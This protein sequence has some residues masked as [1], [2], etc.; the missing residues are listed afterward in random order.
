M[1][2]LLV[3]HIKAGG[4]LVHLVTATLPDATIRWT[5]EGGFVGWGD[6]IWT[7]R[8]ATYGALDSISE[9]TDGIDDDASPVTLSI[10][11]PTISSI[12]DLAAAD[13]QG[14]AVTIHLAGIDRQT[15]HLVGQPYLL[16]TGD[17]DQPRLLDGPERRLEYDILP[18]D[19]FGL[20]PNEEQRQSD[21]FHKSI[22]VGER[23]YEHQTEG[24]KIVFWR[25]DDPN[26]AIGYIS[27]SRKKGG[28]PKEF[29]YDPDAGLPFPMG[30]I[31]VPGTLNYRVGF[32]P[33]NRFNS[34]IATVAASGPIQSF[35]SSTFNDEATSFGSNDIATDGEHSG[36]MWMQRLLGTQ[37]QAALTFPTGLPVAGQPPSGWGAEYGQS[38]KAVFLLTMFENS[39]KTE[40]GGGVPVV[41]NVVEGLLGWDPLDSSSEVGDVSTWAYLAEGGRWALNWCIGRWEGPDGSGGYGTPYLSTIV[42]GIGAPLTGIDTPA[43]ELVAQIADDNGWTVAACPTSADDKIDVLED[44]LQ[45][46]GAVRSRKAGKLSCISYGA[47]QDSVLTVTKR[48]TAGRL[49][50]PLYPSRLERKNTAIARFLSEANNWEMTPIAPI[51]D[52]AWRA[53]DG[54]K[55]SKGLE[56]PFVPD[57]DQAAQLAY[58]E[59]AHAREARAE[60]PMKA[61]LLQLEPGDCFDWDAPEHLLETKA[62]VERRRWDPM[63]FGLKV[64]WATETD[65]KYSAAMAQTGEPPPPSDPNTPPP[66]F[67]EP[68]TDFTVTPDDLDM[69]IA[70]RTP[71][72]VRANHDFVNVLRADD[73]LDFD[74]ASIVDYYAGAPGEFITLTDTVPGPDAYGYWLQAVDTEGNFSDPIGPVQANATQEPDANL[75]TAPSD[76]SDAAWEKGQNGTGVTPVVTTNTGAAPDGTTTAD[77][78][79][80]VTAGIEGDI[81]DHSFVRQ[82]PGGA[83]GAQHGSI[84]MKSNT[85]ADQTVYL[86]CSAEE[87]PVTVKPY[88]KRFAET[89]SG[90]RSLWIGLRG[91]ITG[92]TSAADV[93][94][95]QGHLAMD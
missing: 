72:P 16:F 67:V 74:D 54:G 50:L 69:G 93:L 24:R 53:A 79:Q 80:F 78:I 29:N 30:R 70:Y 22:W 55:R 10:I 83:D 86:R 66:P 13:A 91:T 19:A 11:A 71:D 18:A 15:G 65:A 88:W 21:A 33:T 62:R 3:A 32:G 14:A 28:D 20:Q 81:A 23:G 46:S 37:P 89:G 1:D 12:A 4:P 36:A 25:D 35:V 84:W 47:A 56:F 2:L 6:H 61:Y 5:L 63:T 39:K 38:G 31:M 44:L 73:S 34:I 75:L 9:I 95:W 90:T 17:L 77:R 7:A 60:T 94:V 85:G 42:G 76:F 27:R 58:L 49:E 8:D 26:N 52:S 45:A 48:D 82:L 87:G 68:P 51:T 43:F 59:L 92:T 64:S 57:P 40:F 41:R